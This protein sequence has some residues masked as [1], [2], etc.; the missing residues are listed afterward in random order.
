M[1]LLPNVP[2]RRLPILTNLVENGKEI[3][4]PEVFISGITILVVSTGLVMGV[5]LAVGDVVSVL[6]ARMM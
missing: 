2:L 6:P 1:L 4:R 5:F 3:R